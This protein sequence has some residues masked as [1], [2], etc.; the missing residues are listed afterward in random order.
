MTALPSFNYVR[1]TSPAN[2]DQ[3]SDRLFRGSSVSTEKGTVSQ[4]PMTRNITY[5]LVPLSVLLGVDE[6]DET[7]SNFL[8]KV[9]T[10]VSQMEVH[11]MS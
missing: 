1:M 7:V 2:P 4:I 6:V 5:Y 3:S 8:A 9:N 10:R 11:Y